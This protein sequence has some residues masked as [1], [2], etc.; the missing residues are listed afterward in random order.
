VYSLTG[1]L[2]APAPYCA[3]YEE[4]VRY[5]FRVIARR[6]EQHYLWDGWDEETEE[7]YSHSDQ[8]LAI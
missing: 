7:I 1:S 6:E 2:L 8:A 3:F 4:Q 5:A